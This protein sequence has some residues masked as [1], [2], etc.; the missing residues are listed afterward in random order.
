MDLH[1]CPQKQNE[2]CFQVLIHKT[3]NFLVNA[4]YF[5]RNRRWWTDTVDYMHKQHQITIEWLALI[6]RK[7]YRTQRI[8][9]TLNK[10]LH[11]LNPLK[12]TLTE[13]KLNVN[14]FMKCFKKG[15]EIW[16]TSLLTVKNEAQ[17]IEYPLFKIPSPSNI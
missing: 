9:S 11:P 16:R 1:P 5:L 7:T 12:H 2:L 15:T 3:S 17:N 6:H 14:T 8:N 4:D 10:Q 13:L